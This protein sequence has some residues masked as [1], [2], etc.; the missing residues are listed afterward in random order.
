MGRPLRTVTLL[1]L[2]GVLQACA[3]AAVTE[4]P[5]AGPVCASGEALLLVTNSSGGEVRILESRPG[6]ATRTV[7]A[8]LPAGSH[9]VAIHN[10]Y[11]YSYAAQAVDGR[12][13]LAATTIPRL[14]D[15]SVTLARKCRP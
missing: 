12:G 8:A 5:A 6:S 1:L 11:A 2:A 13:I 9:E 4:E 15:R 14:G 3:S 10:D 7:I